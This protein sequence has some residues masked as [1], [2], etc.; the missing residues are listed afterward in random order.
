MPPKSNAIIWTIIKDEDH[1]LKYFNEDNK[2]LTVLD[3][4]P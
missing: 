2:K 4:H 1:F 3:I